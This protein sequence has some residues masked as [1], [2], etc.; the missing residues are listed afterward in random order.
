MIQIDDAGNGAVLGGEVIG[1]LRIETGEYVSKV[2]PL[3]AYEMFEIPR[4]HTAK[5][6][7]LELLQRLTPSE[8]EEIVFCTGDIFKEAKAY[9]T[10]QG[11]TWREE[12]IIGTLQELVEASFFNSLRTYG[13]P[14]KFRAFHHDYQRFHNLVFNWVCQDLERRSKH[15]KPLRLN[16]GLVSRAKIY[17]TIIQKTCTCGLC[18]Q[19]LAPNSIAIIDKT[20]EQT[21]YYHTDCFPTEIDLCDYQE[22]VVQG[23]TFRSFTSKYPAPPVCEICKQKIKY[24][25]RVINF[26]DKTYHFSCLTQTLIDN[27]ALSQS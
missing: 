23:E 3:K 14:E 7:V 17:R 2:L 10:E 6:I 22:T 24:K 25:K 12:K 11:I 19:P 15:C 13:L 27:L 9:L 18:N 1:A 21:L 16:S 8:D 20:E 26:Q 5:T 4:V